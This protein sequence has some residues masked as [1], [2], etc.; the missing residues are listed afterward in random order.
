MVQGVSDIID[1]P[2]HTA[3]ILVYKEGILNQGGPADIFI[4]RVVYEPEYIIEDLDGDGNLDV[5]GD[6]DGDGNLDVAEDLDGDGNLDVAEDLDS[7]GNL[8][9]AEDLDSDG[10]LDVAEDLDSDGEL[11]EGEDIDGDGKL[12]LV[13]EDIDGDGKLDLVDEDLDLDGNLDVD[14]DIDGD[15]KLDLVDEDV[16]G[17]GKL[18]LVDEDL[19]G[20]LLLDEPELVVENPFAYE[21]VIC[22]AFNGAI[23]PEVGEWLYTDGSNPNYVR[24]LCT[25]QGMN[26]SGSTIITCDDGSGGEDC[27]VKFP[28]D[29]TYEDGKTVQNP[30]LCPRSPSGASA[31][32][33][34]PL[35]AVLARKATLTTHHG[36]TPTTSPRATAASSTAT[37]S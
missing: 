4:R 28:F 36:L 9:V 7:D 18:D 25:V 34:Q 21:N 1:S 33:R 35:M 13:D 2:N 29:A 31:M 30:S 3:A 15:G 11:D 24:G 19:N 23:T 32:A 6:L 14:E 22:D 26:L 17:D 16:D 20:N 37:S 27:A 12:D 8:D 10:N 5:A